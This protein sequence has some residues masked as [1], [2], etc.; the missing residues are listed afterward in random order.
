[1]K[2]DE[3]PI[4]ARLRNDDDPHARFQAADIIEQ[5]VGALDALD[6]FCRSGA[7]DS[8]ALMTQSAAALEAARK[9]A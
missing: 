8:A 5:L 6:T 2:M 3:L 1:M 9:Q 4:C 7:G